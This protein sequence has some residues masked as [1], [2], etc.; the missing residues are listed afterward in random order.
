M[1]NRRFHLAAR[2][3]SYTNF[4]SSLHSTTFSQYTAL[5]YNQFLSLPPLPKIASADVDSIPPKPFIEADC[6]PDCE[7]IVAAILDRVRHNAWRSKN[8]H[9]GCL[10]GLTRP[11]PCDILTA[12]PS[13]ESYQDM[14]IIFGQHPKLAIAEDNPD[15]GCLP[16]MSKIGVQNSV[17]KNSN[18]R[19]RSNDLKYCAFLKLVS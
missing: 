11:K 8:Q 13:G 3:C 9:K 16:C 17:T 2:L 12:S 10:L 1:Q 19:W 14:L 18:S 4:I 6:K 15:M 5:L 7:T